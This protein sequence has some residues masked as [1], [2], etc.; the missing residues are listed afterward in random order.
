[1]VILPPAFF[2]DGNPPGYSSSG[3]SAVPYHM[4][5]PGLHGARRQVLENRLNINFSGAQT[6]GGF[7]SFSSL[8]QLV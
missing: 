2:L 6:N 3:F 8:I 4:S 7:L 5:L 1:M